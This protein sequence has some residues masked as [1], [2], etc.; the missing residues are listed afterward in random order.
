[1]Y[2]QEQRKLAIETFIKLDYSIADTVAT[3][4]FPNRH[5]LSMWWK[6]Y[7]LTGK[8]PVGK[9]HHRKSLY[10]DE[11]ARAA[12][13][14]YMEHGKSLART[15]RALGYPKGRETLLDMLG[16]SGCETRQWRE[17]LLGVY[18]GTHNY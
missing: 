16:E 10:S 17:E 1:M 11:Q 4:G 3:L 14:H 15:M 12:V 13:D 18:E 9:D 5:T 2:S 7:E 6:E 8:V